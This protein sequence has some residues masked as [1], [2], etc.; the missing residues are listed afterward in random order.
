MK[1]EGLRE[2]GPTVREI[3]INSIHNVLKS[4]QEQNVDFVLL[5]GDIFEHNMVSQEY[6]KKVITIFNQYP[7]IPLYLLPGNHDVLG[8]GCIY[9]R[10]IFSQISHL[11]ILSKSD[12]IEVPDATLH[13]CP[14]Y[15]KFSTQD[16]SK[17]IPSVSG[18]EG[19]H[20]GVAH[21]S[22]EGKSPVPSWEGI[23]LPL[24]P[25]CVDKTGIDYLALGHWH[26]YRTFED[27][28]G[29]ARIAY[30]GTH[31]QTN[32][33]EDNAGHCLLV[34]IAGKG[35]APQI[36]PIK[37]GELAWES[38]EFEIRDSASL[39]DLEKY[40]ESI[41][42]IDMVRLVLYGEL[43]LEYQKDLNNILEF[44]STM[45]KNFRVNRESLNI[46]V[47]TQIDTLFDFGDPT[48]DR[49]DNYLKKLLADEVDPMK[50]KIISEALAHLRKFGKEVD[51]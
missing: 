19:I 29:I 45:H 41:K 43:P 20:I 7:D 10:P 40:F 8:A 13:P 48:L 11:T 49:T 30:S 21:G 22:L 31:E 14:V 25:L 18:V 39:I 51:V 17:A 46:S 38:R 47:P 9:N 35:D 15:S 1:G 26:S 28:T 27:S 36:V 5:C 4:A 37:T 16:S 3:R 23:D 24:D 12:S 42:G 44:Q 50:K 34:Q 33:G 2:A 6:V 32:Y